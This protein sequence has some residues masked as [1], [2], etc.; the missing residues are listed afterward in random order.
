[1]F[2]AIVMTG[3]DQ[4]M[5]QKNLTCRSLQ[6]AQKNMFTFS[7]VLVGVNFLFLLLGAL[8]ALYAA[9]FNVA[10]ERADTL[11][12]TI[13]L[14]YLPTGVGLLFLIGLVAAAYSSADSA[15]TALTTS[16]CVDFLGFDVKQTPVETATDDATVL[17]APLE[18]QVEAP[19]DTNTKVRYKVHLAF[20]LLLFLT[21]VLFWW[22]NDESV[23]V[24]LFKLASYT[25]GPLLGLYGF[26]LLTQRRVHDQWVPFVCLSAPLLTYFINK[27]S[28]VLLWGYQFGFELLLL[29]GLLTALG[30]W[31]VSQAPAARTEV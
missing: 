20:S 12:A 5:M 24:M 23:V 21:I 6:D 7:I 11:Y 3:L 28:A 8:L 16:F 15:L 10:F 14:Q 25:Y 30:L 19:L 22:I 13:A 9:Q 1:M 27:N 18:Q 29:N 2:I 31:L 26:G 17:D 4:D